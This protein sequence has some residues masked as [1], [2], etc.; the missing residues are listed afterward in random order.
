MIYTGSWVS[1]ATSFGLR[2]MWADVSLAIGDAVILSGDRVVG[3]RAASPQQSY[4]V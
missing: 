2:Q 4:Y 1:V 3:K